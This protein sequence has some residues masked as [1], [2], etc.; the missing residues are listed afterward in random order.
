MITPEIPLDQIKLSP[1]LKVEADYSFWLNDPEVVRFSEQRHYEHTMESCAAYV[2]SFDHE[3]DHIW[4]IYL[5]GGHVGNITAHRD[6]PNFGAQMGIM[7]GDKSVWG[8]G[9]GTAAWCA[10]MMWLFQERNVRKITAGCMESNFGMRRIMERSG[11]TR[12]AVLYRH[13]LLDGQ[14]EN[15]VTYA[16]WNDGYQAVLG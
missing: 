12:E 16:R 9:V 14:P 13:F 15:M 2:A 5:H 10:V 1:L 3:R 4:G 7:L 11:M 8:C 6:P